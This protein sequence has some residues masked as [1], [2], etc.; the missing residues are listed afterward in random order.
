MKNNYRSL[1]PAIL[2]LTLSL[3]GCGQ[4]QGYTIKGIISGDA[5]GKMVYLYSGTDLVFQQGEVLDSIIISGGKF[6]FKSAAP[7]TAPLTLKILSR[8][9]SATTAEGRPA[10]VPVIPIFVET[11]TVTIKAAY[12]DI[13]L[14][15]LLEPYDYSKLSI[16]GSPLQDLYVN[17]EKTKLE[18]SLNRHKAEQS[19][20]AHRRAGYPGLIS[21]SIAAYAP[22]ENATIKEKAFIEDFVSNNSENV[23]AAYALYDNFFD[24]F[25]SNLQ[26]FTLDEINGIIA[27]LSPNVIESGFGQ[28]LMEKVN[29]H[30]ISAVGAKYTD[31]TLL[32]TNDNPVKLSDYVGKG[33]YVLLEFWGSWCGPCIS[34]F[35]LLKEMYGL[36]H[37][38]GFEIIGIAL[39]NDKSAWHKGVKEHGMTWLQLSDLKAVNSPLMKTYNFIAVPTGILIAPDGTIVDRD[40]HVPHLAQKLIELYGNHFG[41]RY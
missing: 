4:Q 29:M 34:Q 12:E 7:A 39:D 35:P 5:D 36:Y 10:S 8:E 6:E 30:K 9:R 20:W 33:N 2:F 41:N 14:Q 37:P 32:D 23:L 11:G 22:L 25:L 27:S 38:S 31:F 1:I 28:H 21:E 13:P 18:L 26:M 16:T 19:Y 15:A 3:F 17:Y 40:M 24:P